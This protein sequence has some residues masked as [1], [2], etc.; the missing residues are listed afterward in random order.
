MQLNIKVIKMWQPSPQFLHQPPLFRVIP[1]FR[2]VF[3]TPHQVTQFFE[4]PNPPL[5]TM[6]RP[7]GLVQVSSQ[8][9]DN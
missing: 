3:G 5:T 8:L 9:N 6:I 7:Q 4:G 1:L 2:K